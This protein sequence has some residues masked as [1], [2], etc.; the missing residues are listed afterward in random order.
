MGF[1]SFTLVRMSMHEGRD[2]GEMASTMPVE[3][4]QVWREAGVW[5]DL[6]LAEAMA[7][8]ARERPETPLRFHGSAGSRI[9]TLAE[10]QAE[11]LRLAGSL[12]ALGLRQGDVL[13]M[14]L[15]AGIENAMLCQA[16]AMLGCTLLPIIHIYGPHELAYILA[17]SGAKA[18]IVPD[19]WRNIDYLDRLAR[20]PELPALEH[21][22]VM[23]GDVPAG[24]LALDAL[25]AGVAPLVTVDPDAQALLLYTS[26]TTAAPKG[27]RHSSRSLLA[28]LL[29]QGQGRTVDDY[30]L[31]PWPSGHIA[32]TLGVMGHALLGRPTILMEAW[33][34]ALAARLVEQFHVRQMS[35][36]PFHLSGLLE[37][38]ERGGHDITSFEQFLI[39]AT[40]VPPALVAQCEAAGI[41]CCRCY[42]STELPTAT[43]CEPGDP[44]EKR[45][46]TDGRANPGVGVRI[47][48]DAGNDLPVG[49]EG[50]V[51]VR[52][53]ER[54][55]GYTDP[56]LNAVSFLPGGWFLTGDIGKLDAEGFL[57]IT[58]RKK[59]III[60]GGENISSREIEEL[61]LQVP[62]VREAAAIGAPDSRLGE[63]ICAVVTLDPGAEVSIERIDAEFRR[64]GVARQKTPELLVVIEEFPRTPS[65]KIQKA[66]LR[67]ELGASGRLALP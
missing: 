5:V 61:L 23:G 58:D 36:T 15:P 17:D 9:A 14:Q 16:A 45:L 67:R 47:V 39:G 25:P 57:A 3:L 51:A 22:I 7:R 32:G 42:G 33:D 60:R 54:F 2:M 48:D 24:M 43:Q 34:A 63:R 66:E 35:G 27:V 50:E 4:Q 49:V 6:S 65:G 20:L 56:A 1:G 64:I 28:E 21:R 40:T 52:G 38:A 53:A 26:G 31:S 37:A 41:R 30:V 18:L 62:G 59:D 46:N 55:L 13:A 11:G 29:A 10:I 19:R 8:S 12:H 44:L